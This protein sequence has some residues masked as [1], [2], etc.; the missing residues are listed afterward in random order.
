MVILDILEDPYLV[1][2]FWSPVLTGLFECTVC[3][4]YITN[5]LQDI[6]FS[7]MAIG[8]V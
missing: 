7:K 4:L 6:Q 8:S 3:L 1:F 2:T 5:R